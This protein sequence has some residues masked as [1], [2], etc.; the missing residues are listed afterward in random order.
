VKKK[1]LFVCP[2]NRWEARERSLVHDIKIAL[3]RGNDVA[4]Y[5]LKGSSI[6]K[7]LSSFKIKKHYHPGFVQTHFFLWPK[8]KILSHLLEDDELAL[9]HCYK[10]NI[11]WPICFFLRGNKEVSVIHSQ[12][13][14]LKQNYRVLWHRLLIRRCDMIFVPFEHLVKNSWSRLGMPSRKIEVRPPLLTEVE[15]KNEESSIFDKFE[16]FFSVGVYVS[17]SDKNVKKFSSYIKSLEVS[18]EYFNWKK[19]IKLVFVTEGPWSEKTVY[20]ALKQ[21]V[22]DAGVEEHV[23]FYSGGKPANYLQHFDL[24]MSLLKGEG[25]DDFALMAIS[26]GTPILVPRHPSTVEFFSVYGRVGETYKNND[27][28]EIVRMWEKL[29]SDPDAYQDQIESASCQIRQDH[30]YTNQENQYL[31]AYERVVMRRERYRQRKAESSS[32]KS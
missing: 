18:N 3:A 20:Q 5:G 12:Y 22:L 21:S 4:F 32:S 14:E 1:I 29:L 27:V 28:R 19:P 6:D 24:W 25:L 15:N 31:R 16:Q 9:V 26:I 7:N 10:L 30:S 8:L 2:T 23:V 13:F 11:L 17:D